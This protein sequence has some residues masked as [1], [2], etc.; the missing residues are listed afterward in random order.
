MFKEVPDVT[1]LREIVKVARDK[2]HLEVNEF[3]KGLYSAMPDDDCS[4]GKELSESDKKRVQ[5]EFKRLYKEKLEELVKEAI[6][7]LK[8]TI[9]SP[10]WQFLQKI[11]A[12]QDP[13]LS[14]ADFASYAE[15]MAFLGYRQQ[16]IEETLNLPKRVIDYCDTPFNKV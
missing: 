5:E 15:R 13:G 9:N 14:S 8:N 3:Q 2:A 11:I 1:L 12:K 4:T 6:Q 10:G 16:V 7:D